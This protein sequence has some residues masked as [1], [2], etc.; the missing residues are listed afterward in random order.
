MRVLLIRP[1]PDGEATARLLAQRN[2]EAVVAPLIEIR[3]IDNPT[4]DL[5]AVQAV[6]VTSANGARA[7]AGATARRDVRLFAVGDASAETAAQ[8]GFED[9]TSAGGDVGALAAMVRE[10]L[11]AAAGALVHVIGSAVAGDLS[12]ELAKYGFAVRQIQLYQARTV[13]NLPEQARRALV[14]GA[15]AAALFYSPRTAAHFA[16]LVA[17][18]GLE[19][20]CRPLIAVCL[21]AAVAETLAALPFAEVR[22]ARVPDQNSLFAVLINKN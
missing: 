17:A 9:V 13:E 18:A 10:R 1:R 4:L 8:S 15:V 22:I 16:H 2:I 19:S 11:S 7:L 5:E 21:S 14:E 20:Y 3:E 6:L 12:G